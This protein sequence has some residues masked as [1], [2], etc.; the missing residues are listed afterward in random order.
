MRK[1]LLPLFLMVF[2]LSA[3]VGKN[4]KRPQIDLPE[5]NTQQNAENKALPFENEQ[6]WTIFNDTVLNS[7]EE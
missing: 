5:S 3:C 6:W 4:Y 7:F 1:I 2:L